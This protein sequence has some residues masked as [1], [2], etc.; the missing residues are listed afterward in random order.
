MNDIPPLYSF[1]YG[2]KE[3]LKFVIKQNDS[4]KTCELV[5]QNR[6][7]LLNVS[8]QNDAA[9]IDIPFNEQAAVIKISRFV[10]F[11]P[12]QDAF[13]NAFAQYKNRNI[14]CLIIDLRDN[15]GGDLT[16]MVRL[17]SMLIN[18]PTY[19]GAIK[20]GQL[21]NK[22]KAFLPEIENGYERPIQPD[23]NH[24]DGKLIHDDER[25]NIFG[26]GVIGC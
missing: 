17:F 8:T 11:D 23:S 1:T 15:L 16:Q 20:I 25:G 6:P 3:K 14:K 7:Q 10:W 2:L 21:D 9:H 19:L 13:I 12:K 22:Q 26:G 24:F 5:V 18:K 4:V